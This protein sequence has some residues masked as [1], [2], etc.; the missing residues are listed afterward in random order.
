MYS[1][2]TYMNT[3]GSH[4]EASAHI[5]MLPYASICVMS[6]MHSLAFLVPVLWNMPLSCGRTMVPIHHT[7][8]ML[9]RC[10]AN[11]K[12]ECA[13]DYGG[14]WREDFTVNGRTQTYHACKDNIELYKV[15]L[16]Y[17]F[18]LLCAPYCKCQLVH[19]LGARGQ[20]GM[21]LV[22]SCRMHI[23]VGDLHYLQSSVWW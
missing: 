8:T 17:P 15:T 9:C 5:C 7:P 19:C 11:I 20:L 12:D 18:F 6:W 1:A 10:I 21:T 14:C 4:E 22:G 3:M 13:H 2:S 16:V 23:E